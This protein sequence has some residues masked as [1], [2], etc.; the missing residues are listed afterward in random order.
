LNSQEDSATHLI[1]QEALAISALFTRVDRHDLRNSIERGL[2]L[3]RTFD[4]HERELSL[5]AGQH[6]VMCH[7]GCF[8]EAVEVSWRSLELVRRIDSPGGI[9]MSEWM[10]GCAYHLAGDQVN[11][12]RHTEEGFKHAAAHGDRKS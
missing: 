1:L 8:R 12:L 10:L 5:L 9:V 4:D 6:I 11:A 7:I 3:A 2:S